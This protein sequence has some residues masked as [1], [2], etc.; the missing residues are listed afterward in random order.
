[1]FTKIL[2]QLI[3]GQALSRQQ[4]QEAMRIIMSGNATEAQIG[5]FLT[6]L[7]IKGETSEEIAGFAETMRSY[8][9]KITCNQQE[10][11][12]TCGTGGDKKGTFNVSTAVAFV[13][14]GAGVSVAKHGNHGISSGCGSADVLKTLGVRLDLPPRA[15]GEAIDTLQVGFLYAPAFH[16][17]MKYAG[18]PRRELGFRTVFNLLGPLT[19]P[20]GTKNQLMGVYDRDLTSKLAEVLLR[21]EAKHAMVVHGLDGL[22]EI[23]IAAPTQIS[24]VVS[25]K[26]K[27][28]LLDPSDYGF[29]TNDK[30]NYTDGTSLASA[31]IITGVLQGKPNS[32]RDIVL[33]NTAAALVVAGKA[34]S[35]QEGLILAASSIDSGAALAKLDALRQ[36][37]QQ[38][39]E[40]S[41]S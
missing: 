31:Q 3:V 1:M 39:K 38:Y 17:A 27:T 40:E 30:A 34:E 4:A 33:L 14:A 22:D 9:V 37:S 28:Y 2:N 12:D 24:E 36:F 10:V 8:T 18:K 35:I 15:V 11:I 21:L 19:N 32:C 41:V 25:G 29:S 13:V 23:S 5:S 6:A 26:I 16:P 7:R 20:L